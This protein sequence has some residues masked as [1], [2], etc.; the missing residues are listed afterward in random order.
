MSSDNNKEI[1][2][3]IRMMIYLKHE[4]IRN[5]LVDESKHIELAL[6][7]IEEKAEI[8]SEKTSPDMNG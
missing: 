1:N 5:D 3:L 6:K 4:L 8:Y 7:A 2:A